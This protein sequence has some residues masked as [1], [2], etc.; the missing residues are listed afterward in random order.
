[1]SKEK[2]FYDTLQN[3]FIGAKLEGEGGFINLMKMKS[4]YYKSIESVLKKDIEAVLKKFPKFKDELF[5]KLY[6]FFSRYFTESGSIY[7]NSTPF[8]NNIYEQV[9]TDDRDVILFWKTQMLYYVK[10]DR[11]FRSMPDVTVD[12]LKFFFD[13]SKIDN[14]KANEKR[15]LIYE[16]G[17]IKKDKTISFIVRY[18]EKG[19]TTKNEDILKAIRKKDIKITEEQLEKAF[20]V[21]QRQSE[22]DFFIN[23]DAKKFLREQFKLWSYQYFWDGANEW[24]AERVN[25]IQALKDIAYKIIDFVSQFED[26]LVKIW[27]K[28]KFVKNSNYVITLDRI[29]DSKLIKKLFAHKGMKEQI[30]EWNELGI[31]L[32]KS[33]KQEELFD[34]KIH[35]NTLKKEFEHLP[36]DTK[37]FKD[38]ELEILSLFDNLDD[39]LDGRLIKSE[40]YQALNTI[41]PKYKEEVQTIYIDPPFNLDSSDQFLYRTN[42]KNANWATLLENRLR[43]SKDFLKDSGSIFVRCDY[44]GNWIVRCL[45][46]EVYRLNI[47]NEIIVNRVKKSDEGANKYNA[48]T[49]TVY[50][51]SKDK[52]YYFK[53]QNFTN[54]KDERWHAMDSQGQGKPSKIFGKIIAPPKGRHWT[55]GQEKIDV[56]EKQNKIRITENGKVQYLISATEYQIH[57]TNWSDIPGYTSTTGFATENSEK[58]LIRVIETG[59]FN[60]NLILDFFL[61]SGTTTAVAHKLGRKWLGVEMGEHFYSVILPRMKR[62]LAYDKSGISKEVKEYKG[63]GFFKYYELEQYEEALSKCK[64]SDGDLFSVEGR[65]DYEQYVFMKDE[66]LLDSIELDY[67]K[68]KVNVKLD[69]IYENIDIAETLSNLSG[70][71][72]KR[73]EKDKV[74]FEDDSEVNTKE[75]DFRKIKPLIWWG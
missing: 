65:S 53:I 17:D 26:E 14:K 18:S 68:N 62:V 60:R 25:E 57:D 45:M 49:D 46:D 64:Y 74:I 5:D 4:A 20:S 27:N 24:S 55:F 16:L 32:N 8:H 69:N 70:K 36:I 43:L 56:L 13:A 34:N 54:K 9:Y 19:K 63:G 59:S 50:W 61:G 31:T 52:K 37:F 38:L 11:I 35:G 66:K 67:K 40:N 3:V 30:K 2:K 73:I 10:T 23:K 28:P 51:Y 71:W 41:L 47:L 22:V 72:I 48:A 6:T 12:E 44:N 1:M 21:F 75:L 42:Y 58:L 33:I 29:S 39:A 15:N 7:F